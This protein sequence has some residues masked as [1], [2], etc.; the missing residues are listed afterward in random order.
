LN[1]VMKIWKIVAVAG[2]WSCPGL[3]GCN[4]SHPT[5]A[6]LSNEYPPARD[7]GSAD[8]MPVYQGWWSVAQFPDPVPAGQ[9]SDPVRVV[10]GSDYAYA[11]LAPGWDPA[12]GMPPKALVPLRSAQKISVARGDTLTFVVADDATFGNCAAGKP[13]AQEDADFITQ[14]IFPGPFADQTYDAAHCIASPVSGGE[15][16]AAGAPAAEGGAGG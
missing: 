10:P 4:T 3:A 16:G 8:S 15:G 9:V 13:L 2:V 5:S 6:V 7:A 12:S 1:V 11:L 14:R